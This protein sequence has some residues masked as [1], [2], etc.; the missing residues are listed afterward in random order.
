MPVVSFGMKEQTQF[1]HDGYLR[2]GRVV[3]VEWIEALCSRIDDIMLGV[4]KY[5]GM[6]MQLDSTSGDYSAVPESSPTHKG[7]TL[8]YRRIDQL[9]RDPQFLTYMQHPLFRR[10]TRVLVGTDVS[11][12]RAMFMNKPA[13]QGTPL[14]WHQDIGVGWGLDTNP[15]CTIWTAL[16]P[17]TQANGCM[18]IVP[19]SHLLGILNEQHFPSEADQEKYA[20]ASRRIFLEAEKGEAILLHNWLLHRS[21]VNPTGQPRRAFSIAYM[22]AAT[23]NVKTGETFPVIFGT[24]ALKPSE[25]EALYRL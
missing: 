11:I 7:A 6:A 18:Q 24:D 20:P 25:M 5:S 3:P 8:A 15:I 21:G 13:S 10:I 22:D 14:P 9:D 17:A 19:G 12:F 23:R 1:R 4:V 16:D 2:L